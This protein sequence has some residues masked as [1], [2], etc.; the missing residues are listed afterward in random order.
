[1]QKEIIEPVFLEN[2]G[3]ESNPNI[4]YLPHHAVVWEDIS[5]TKVRIVF[6]GSARLSNNELSII[7]PLR[8]IE[9]L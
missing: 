1:M 2:K 3:R 9:M 7:C 4:R 5:T 6:N 8:K